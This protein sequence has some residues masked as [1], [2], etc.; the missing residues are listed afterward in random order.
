MVNER[1]GESVAFREQ[2]R[3]LV[4]GKLIVVAARGETHPKSIF[5]WVLN[6]TDDRC[7]VELFAAP[8][9]QDAFAGADLGPIEITPLSAAE[10]VETYCIDRGGSGEFMDFD[11]AESPH[12]AWAKEQINGMGRAQ[13]TDLQSAIERSR[14]AAPQAAAAS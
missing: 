8:L 12:L 6:L 5:K 14:A 4:E 2:I 3:K 9:P 1:N 13:L 10:L 11:P 7:E